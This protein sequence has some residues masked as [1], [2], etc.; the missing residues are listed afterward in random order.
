MVVVKECN[1]IC[2]GDVTI[3]RLQDRAHIAHRDIGEVLLVL[4]Q[5]GYVLAQVWMRHSVQL[6]QYFGC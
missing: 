6:V 2:D 5:F 1:V 3:Q 4:Q